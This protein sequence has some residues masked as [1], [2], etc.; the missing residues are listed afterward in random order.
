[1]SIISEKFGLWPPGCYGNVVTPR[2]TRSGRGKIASKP[3]FHPHEMMHDYDVIGHVPKLMAF[4]A[5]G[6][7]KNN[8]KVTIKGKFIAWKSTTPILLKAIRS[9]SYR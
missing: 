7:K 5:N 6:E 8:G 2:V 9:P 1:M 3:Y 4:V